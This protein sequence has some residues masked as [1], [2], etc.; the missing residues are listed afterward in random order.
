MNIGKIG[1]AISLPA[2]L[3]AAGMP[4]L[5]ADIT[6]PMQ[7]PVYTPVPMALIGDI[8]L[9]AGFSSIEDD[10]LSDSDDD[11][12]ID[13]LGEGRVNI[14]VHSGTMQLQLDMGAYGAINDGYAMGAAAFQGH[15]WHKRDNLAY[16]F[17]G[18]LAVAGDAL[19]TWSIGA[20]AE[21]YYGN[22]TLGAYAT[23]SFASNEWSSPSGFHAAGYVE[24]YVT[25]DH[26]LGFELDYYSVD[27]DYISIDEWGVVLSG[28]KRVSGTP[29]SY[30]AEAGYADWSVFDGKSSYDGNSWGAMGGVRIAL[31]GMPG[32]TLQEHD[33]YLPWDNVGAL[34]VYEELIR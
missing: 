19:A 15:V 21:H 17:L 1:L 31:G 13:L 24:H 32:M 14:P 22:T 8:K 3:A 26:K 34:P 11:T 27:D 18:G 2:F 28:E 30:W 25:P 5:A 12:F 33:R 4:A 23:Y 7:D 9:G 6:Y 16:G 20:E 29:F 10:Y